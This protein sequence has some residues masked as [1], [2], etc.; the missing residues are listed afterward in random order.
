MHLGG[1]VMPSL[2]WACG[3]SWLWVWVAGVGEASALPCQGC[4]GQKQSLEAM[5]VSRGP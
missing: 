2:P 5:L 3:Q 4:L 1:A